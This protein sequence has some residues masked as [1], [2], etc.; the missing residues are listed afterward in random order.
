MT[1]PRSPRVLLSFV[2][3]L[4]ACDQASCESF[5]EQAKPTLEAVLARADVPRLFECTELP[6][7]EETAKCL[8]AEVLT[9]GLEVALE[10]A[11]ELAEQARDAANAQAGAADMSDA[12]RE[13]LAA[14]LDA[15]MDDL[16]QEIAKAQ[17]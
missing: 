16:A 15:A 13:S 6:T 17:S 7:T 10:R 12:Q 11:T 4:A 8:G 14:D 5:S 9:Q 1:H 3:L 2:L